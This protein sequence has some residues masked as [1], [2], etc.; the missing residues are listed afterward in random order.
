MASSQ[1]FTGMK[2]GV[3]MVFV[4][5]LI[6]ASCA[7][8]DATPGDG[9]T[10]TTSA[11]VT[12]TTPVEPASTAVSTTV[13]N[14]PPSTSAAPATTTTA[15]PRFIQAPAFDSW[16]AILAS[17][18]VGEYDREAAEAHAMEL[19]VPSIGIALSDD[20]PSL[21]PGYWVVFTAP[22][23]VFDADYTCHLLRGR[24]PDCYR[25]YFGVDPAQ[26]FSRETGHML[27]LGGEDGVFRI[28][29][30]TTGEVVRT[31]GGFGG[32][33][34][35]PGEPQLDLARWHTY[36]S[37]WNEDSWFSCDGSD[38]ALIMTDLTTGRS[39]KI[40]DGTS[41]A[42]SGDDGRLAYLAA[43]DCYPDPQEPQFVVAPFNTIVVRNLATGAETRRTI[44]L[45]IDSDG[46]PDELT[47][48]VWGSDN[49]ELFALDLAG[50]VQR[51]TTGDAAGELVADL[52]E[53]G[54]W[55]LIGY[56]AASDRLL[57]QRE[58]WTDGGESNAFWWLNPSTGTTELLLDVAGHATAAFDAGGNMVGIG[59][60][61]TLI[62]DGEELPLDV[63]IEFF[64]W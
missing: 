36:Y 20:Y 18:P 44:P 21:N 39:E 23:D 56:D 45:P 58:V 6:V 51:F 4:S 5:G 48:V 27:A 57:A 8:S 15:A 64:D 40:A 55:Q 61:S 46:S 17:L 53:G 24:L 16:A 12:S 14:P 10:P 7:G 37:V 19:R 3:A 41:P 13:A 63:D 59:V 31:V 32:D 26:R 60:G 47:S 42:L 34:Q 62:V 33:G 25:R 50:R 29:D 52:D 1:R 11:G 28:V 9:S 43:S 38:G 49:T 54:H 2:R 22:G 35:Y 30:F